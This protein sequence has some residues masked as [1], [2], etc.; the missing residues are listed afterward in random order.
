MTNP[1][2]PSGKARREF[3]RRLGGAAVACTGT[4]VGTG[5]LGTVP[6]A[7]KSD[8]AAAGSGSFPTK[9]YDWTKHRWAFG[10]D[11]AKCI[12]CLRCVEA[13]KAENNVPGDAH[14]FNTWVER[15]VYL[16]GETGAR[17]DSHHDPVNIAA[18]GSEGEYRFANRYKD[19]KVEKAFFVP[20]L[21]N[22]CTHPACV[23]VCP[24]GATFQT[25]DGV[26]LIDDKYCIGCQYCVQACP[27]GARY[28]N[29]SKGVSQKCYWCYHRI[30]K[31]LQPACV[32]AC[33]VGARVFGDRNDKQSPISLFIRNN[34]VQ[35][36]RPESGN[37]PNVFYV[38]IDKEVS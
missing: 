5:S 13:C 18:S 37:A 19:A 12:G 35:V 20:K 17:V 22:Q 9:D 7:P 26:V 10:V 15:Y 38:G 34:R 11:A 36:L 31:G 28:F 8:G 3:L 16:E 23:Q 2:D 1:S 29:A 14:H 6:N 4:L 27:Y 21:C 30:T 24:T 33:P 32:E 25:K